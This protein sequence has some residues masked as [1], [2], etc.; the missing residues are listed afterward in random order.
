MESEI[1]EVDRVA[2]AELA[3]ALRA[4]GPD[5]WAGL[6]AQAFS[7]SRRQNCEWAA[8]RVHE[9]VIGLLESEAVEQ[10]S[11]RDQRWTDGFRYAEERLSTQSPLGLLAIAASPSRSKG[12][13][14]RGMIRSA[15]QRSLPG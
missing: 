1:W 7:K 4:A 11:H 9:S 15:R 13:I 6:L 2:A 5:D 12:Q 3:A 14:L 8:R 10:F